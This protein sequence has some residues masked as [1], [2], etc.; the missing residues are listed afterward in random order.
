MFSIICECG[1]KDHIDNFISL[2]PVRKEKQLTLD[3]EE[4]IMLLVDKTFKC[5]NCGKIEV[6]TTSMGFSFVE[7]PEEY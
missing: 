3:G 5:P 4:V 6:T 2:S 1:Y 7:Q